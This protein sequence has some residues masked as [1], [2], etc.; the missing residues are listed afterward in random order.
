MSLK[1]NKSTNKS[2]QMSKL[3]F[4]PSLFFLWNLVSF[5]VTQS[6]EPPIRYTS[7]STE[8]VEEQTLFFTLY[9]AAERGSV[10]EIN[11]ALIAGAYRYINSIHPLGSSPLSIAVQNGHSDAMEV[12]IRSGAHVNGLIVASAISRWGNDSKI[13]GIL[14]AAMTA[15]GK[16][17][18]TVKSESARM[19]EGDV[20][21]TG[22]YQYRHSQTNIQRVSPALM[23]GMSY[24]CPDLMTPVGEVQQWTWVPSHAPAVAGGFQSPPTT[25]RAV[26]NG[27]TPSLVCDSRETDEETVDQQDIEK[28][29]RKRFFHSAAMGRDKIIKCVL[30]LGVPINARNYAHLTALHVAAERGHA[31]VVRV[32]LRAGADPDEKTPSGQTALMLAG[33]RGHRDIVS[34]LQGIEATPTAADAA[35]YDMREYDD[36]TSIFLPPKRHYRFLSPVQRGDVNG[37][38]DALRKKDVD[39]ND[40]YLDGRSLLELAAHHQ[41]AENADAMVKILISRMK[42]A[43]PINVRNGNTLLDDMREIG[44]LNIVNMINNALEQQRISL[45]RQLD[46]NLENGLTL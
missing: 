40:I 7:I 44:R 39:P 23:A 4:L 25:V 35:V 13:T 8:S 31:N 34:I 1:L 32:L 41:D 29:R 14:H 15:Q 12:L 19:Y 2:F 16:A 10:E 36:E 43:N 28:M 37:L 38:K 24:E 18:S 33:S 45:Q 42:V 26:S 30:K 3:F 27:I 5:H 46:L 21:Y 11:A 22:D 20:P 9:F 17:A 6:M